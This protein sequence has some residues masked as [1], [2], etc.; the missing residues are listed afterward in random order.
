MNRRNVALS[1]AV[2]PLAAGL[3]L[4][5]GGNV[6]LPGRTK[7]AEL[8]SRLETVQA[9]LPV[10][11]AELKRDR[12]SESACRGDVPGLKARWK[13]IVANTAA[14]LAEARRLVAELKLEIREAEARIEPFVEET[15]PPAEQKAAVEKKA[16]PEK[17]AVRPITPTQGRPR[18]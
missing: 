1:I 11:E 14:R 2:I 6:P 7:A 3:L 4:F 18:R 15:V 16:T 10:L 5:S 13:A 9:S 17:K 8:Q 12:L